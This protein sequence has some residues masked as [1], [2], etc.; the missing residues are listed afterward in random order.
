MR[1]RT[2][3]QQSY[4]N[5]TTMKHQRNTTMKHNNEKQH[6]N[7]TITQQTKNNNRTLMKTTMEHKNEKQESYNNHRAMKKQGNTIMKHNNERQQ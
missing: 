5:R 3:V 7:K 6:L 2:I 1:K 4:N